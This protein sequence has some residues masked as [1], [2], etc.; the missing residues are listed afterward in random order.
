MSNLTIN[1]IELPT[2]LPELID[3]YVD[4]KIKSD[5]YRFTTVS[6][7]VW[8]VHKPGRPNYRGTLAKRGQLFDYHTRARNGKGYA[9][10]I[11]AAPL[12]A[13]LEAI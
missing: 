2:Q 13:I 11:P 7:D 12:N 9:S 6:P 1:P 5:L 8:L 10:T 3:E 4:V